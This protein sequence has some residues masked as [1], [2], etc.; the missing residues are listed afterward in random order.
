ME[1][2]KKD[3]KDILNT[4]QSELKNLHDCVDGIGRE[5]PSGRLQPVNLNHF[6]AIINRIIAFV[7]DYCFIAENKKQAVQI[8]N[9]L[10]GIRDE[11]INCLDISKMDIYDSQDKMMSLYKDIEQTLVPLFS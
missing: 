4:L 6:I 11:D 7:S 10:I 8:Q 1:N 9:N 2:I 5:L 3:S